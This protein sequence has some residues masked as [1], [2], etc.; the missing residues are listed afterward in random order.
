[1]YPE[2][3]WD[4][5]SV[6][7]EDGQYKRLDDLSRGWCNRILLYRFSSIQ[8]IKIILKKNKKKT[9]SLP[10]EYK[11]KAGATESWPLAQ[12]KASQCRIAMRSTVE[13][14][15]EEERARND[16]VPSRYPPSRGRHE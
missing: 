11:T 15:E 9:K 10:Q 16:I 7:T 2:I 3:L 12:L 14:E 1:M 8:A 6:P 5:N 4:Q 13:E